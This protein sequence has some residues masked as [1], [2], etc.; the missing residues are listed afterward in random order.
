MQ[1]AFQSNT[2]IIK[3]EKSDNKVN[4]AIRL[5]EIVKV[6]KFIVG[7]ALGLNQNDVTQSDIDIFLNCCAPDVSYNPDVAYKETASHIM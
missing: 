7:D 6:D 1:V 4:K 2:L 5:S 3:S